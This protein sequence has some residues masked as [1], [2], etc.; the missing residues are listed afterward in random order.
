MVKKLWK[1]CRMFVSFPCSLDKAESEGRHGWIK[2]QREIR[3]IL[4][5]LKLLLWWCSLN[6][7]DRDRKR[8]GKRDRG[9]RDRTSLGDCPGQKPVGF[10]P[11]HPSKDEVLWD[12]PNAAFTTTNITCL[13]VWFFK[14]T[15]SWNKFMFCTWL[16]CDGKGSDTL[17]NCETAFSCGETWISVPGDLRSREAHVRQGHSKKRLVQEGC[18]E[19]DTPQLPV[20]AAVGMSPESSSADGR[21]SRGWHSSA[22]ASRL[23]EGKQNKQNTKA[24]NRLLSSWLGVV[25]VR[26]TVLHFKNLAQ[27][28]NPGIWTAVQGWQWW[29]A[30]FSTDSTLRRGAMAHSHAPAKVRSC[31][32]LQ[33]Y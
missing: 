26:V 32:E 22:Q 9:R 13:Q 11:A 33:A 28:S 27:L 5:Q 21:G 18:W 14:L 23:V 31:S 8:K 25:T 10:R 7:I 30:G 17:N 16:D 19:G 24:G 1:G 15:Y 29:K 4:L 2:M 12:K 6:E 20:I 3:T